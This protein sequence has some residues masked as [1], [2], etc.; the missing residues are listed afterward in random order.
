MKAATY[1]RYS[2]DLQRSTSIDDQL[3]NCRRRADAEGWV[4]TETY[5][6]EAISGSDANRP[7]YQAMLAAAGR[8]EF[9]VLIVDDLSRFARDSVEQEQ[10]IRRLEFRGIRIVSTSDGYDSQSKA[11]KVHRQVKGMMNEIFLDDLAEKV[12]RG[13]TG[14]AERGYWCGGKPYGYNLRPVVDATRLDPYGQPAKIGTK[15]EINPEQADVVREMFERYANG[16]STRAIAAELNRRGVPS[17]GA[18]W[19]RKVR[20]CSGWAGSAVRAIIVNELFTG[21]VQWNTS[22]FVRDPDTG[23]HK[24]RPRPR[25]EW[26]EFHDEALRIVSDAVFAAAQRRGQRGGDVAKISRQPKGPGSPKYLL[27]GL[28]KCTCGSAYIMVNQR[29]Y[30]CGGHREGACKASALV[31]RDH[32]QSVVLEPITKGLLAPERVERMAR[33][34]EQEYTK[35]ARSA[36]VRTA[37]APKELQA[38][39]AKVARLRERQRTGDPDMTADE[40]QTVIDRVLAER[41]KLEAARPEPRA[42][43]KIFAVLPNA[44]DLYRKQINLGLDG[45]PRQ[46]LKAR[47]VLKKLI[48]D[49]VVIEQAED[50]KV[51]ARYSLQPAALLAEAV[52]VDGRGDRI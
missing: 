18:T 15:L 48:T 28:L 23:K 30:G 47:V 4:I 37:E 43:A 46:A 19:K 8:G 51:W 50:G 13:L 49:S 34:L 42:A 40:L 12:H 32:M 52:G 35:R 6:D 3:R 26:S 41:R 21:R 22:Q 38:I 11:R 45:D 14:Q 44:A 5:A 1:C 2:S 25:S 16:E 29:S 27:A 9:D 24:R 10:A 39:D 36:L 17:S 31:R 33:E 7:Q 20:R